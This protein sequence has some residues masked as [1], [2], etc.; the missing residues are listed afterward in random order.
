MPLAFYGKQADATFWDAHWENVDIEVNAKNLEGSLLAHVMEDYLPRNGKILEGGCG[1]G[2]WVVYLRGK[3]YDIA[4]IDFAENTIRQIKERFPDLPVET[5][6]ILDLPYPDSHF[7]AYISLGVVEHFKEGP[8]VA[9]A[10]AHRILQKDGFIL[11]S[12]PY[13]NFLRRLKKRLFRSY[14]QQKEGEKFYQWA[15]TKREIKSIIEGIG[16]RVHR[17]I[18]FDAVKGIKDEVPWN[19][20]ALSVIKRGLSE[21]QGQGEGKEEK[22]N[23]HLVSQRTKL[24][25]KWILGQYLVRNLFGHML[26]IVAEK[27]ERGTR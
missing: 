10:E 27:Q 17:I 12:I 6:S 7:S 3:G 4:G 13:F 5:G 11:C 26:L 2:Q 19:V 20:E 18:P 16:F 22:D 14:H 23:S 24:V 15:F 9:L 25:F 1:L 21:D 8:E